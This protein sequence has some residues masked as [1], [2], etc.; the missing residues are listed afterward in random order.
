MAHPMHQACWVR[1]CKRWAIR[2]HTLRFSSEERWPHPLI[3]LIVRKQ[4]SHKPVTSDM[5]Q[6]EIQGEAGSLSSPSS[7]TRS[8]CLSKR[9][10]VGE[11]GGGLDSNKDVSMAHMVFQIDWLARTFIEYCTRSQ[12][13][14]LAT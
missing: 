4:P 14:R 2:R 8:A 10:S 7:K 5:R 12:G 9:D 1:P 3:S 6:T 13:I 11:S